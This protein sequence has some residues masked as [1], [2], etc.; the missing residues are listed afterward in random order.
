MKIEITQNKLPGLSAA[1]RS[2][3]AQVVETTAA[4]IEA[5]AKQRTPVDTGNLRASISHE[6]NGLQGS[7]SVAADYGFWIEVATERTSPQ[8]FLGPAVEGEKDSF[9][10]RIEKRLGEVT[11]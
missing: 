4:E 1:L 11:H 9:Q 2:A 6:T 8:P 5:G 10:Q 3:L 7:V